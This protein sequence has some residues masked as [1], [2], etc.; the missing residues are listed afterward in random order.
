[1]GILT[2]AVLLNNGPINIKKGSF[3]LM[4]KELSDFNGL[5]GPGGLVCNVICMLSNFACYF[6]Q[7]LTFFKTDFMK[8]NSIRVSKGLD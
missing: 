2:A 6:C 5:C 8:K 3:Y 4:K 7:L 1:M